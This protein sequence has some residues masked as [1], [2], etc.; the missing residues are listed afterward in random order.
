MFRRFFH[1]FTTVFFVLSKVVLIF[2]MSLYHKRYSFMQN[3]VRGRA[4]RGPAH[5]FLSMQLRT[6]IYRTAR[7]IDEVS[8][9]APSTG[10]DR[11]YFFSVLLLFPFSFTFPFSYFSSKFLFVFPF[12]INSIFQ[13]FSFWLN[14]LK[15]SRIYYIFTILNVFP[16]FKFFF[17]FRNL[18]KNIEFFC[19]LIVFYVFQNCLIFSK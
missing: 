19:I 15:I 13:N 6:I 14:F 18:L 4:R 3:F 8:H 10:M 16:N 12:F 7:K 5:F 11:F 2:C 9:M 1:P 17:P